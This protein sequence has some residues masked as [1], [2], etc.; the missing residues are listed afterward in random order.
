MDGSLEALTREMSGERKAVFERVWQRV[1]GA[2]PAEEVPGEE[3]APAETAG[4]ELPA[5]T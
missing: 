4:K 5:L 1:M 2:L 3:T